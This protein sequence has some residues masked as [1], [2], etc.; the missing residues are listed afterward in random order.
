MV[1]GVAGA[2][3]AAG[4]VHAAGKAAPANGSSSGGR[5][6]LGFRHQTT[7]NFFSSIYLES[8]SSSTRAA[9]VIKFLMGCWIIF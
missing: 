1:I 7:I 3:A 6:S 5:S 4:Q 9:Y 8:S 2:G